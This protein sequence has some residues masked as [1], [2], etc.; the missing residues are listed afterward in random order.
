MFVK[1][2]KKVSLVLV[3]LFVFC[4]Y[5][6]C[7]NNLDGENKT[8]ETTDKI[9]QILPGAENCIASLDRTYYTLVR[10]ENTSEAVLQKITELINEIKAKSGITID[11]KDDFLKKGESADEST[12]FLIGY[13]NR[14]Q[15]K[16][17]MA[18]IG[19]FDW[20]IDIRGNK[21]VLA[22]HTEDA[23]LEAISYLKDQLIDY[24]DGAI[25]LRETYYCK[26]DVSLLFTDDNKLGDY[27]IIYPSGEAEIEIL[28]NDFKELLK[29]RYGVD[30]PVHSDSI[31]A[32]ECEILL[33]AV[34]R[35]EVS[36]YVSGMSSLEEY[37]HYM[38]VSGKKILF[39]GKNENAVETAIENFKLQNNIETPFSYT[40]NLKSDLSVKEIAYV[41]DKKSNP[42][43]DYDLRVMSYNILSDNLGSTG[44]NTSKKRCPR[45]C[46]EFMY[47]MPDIV[48]VQEVDAVAYSLMEEY[49]GHTYA[50]T[51]KTN[52]DKYGNDHSYT[53]IL[54]N[55][56]TLRLI[57]SG[58]VNY[59]KVYN[60]LGGQTVNI[61]VR[62]VNWGVFEKIDG[63][64]QFI[65]ISTHWNNNN[66]G[67]TNVRSYQ[68]AQLTEV[69]NELVEKYSL[70]VFSTG[71]F[72]SRSTQNY[73]VDYLNNTNQSNSHD[74]AAVDMSDI[75]GDKRIDHITY[76]PDA[77]E[78]VYYRYQ[79]KPLLD[80]ASDHYPVCAD[81]KLKK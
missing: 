12:E 17:A 8:T 5:L 18:E 52:E 51:S 68:A 49:I 44:T 2:I 26:S 7:T 27:S 72:N 4:T 69:V 25:Y 58:V 73:F 11:V 79:V 59:D 41:Y 45:W 19:Y 67:T 3:L 53:S 74:N 76:T 70:P 32:S 40:L 47:R 29:N 66:H 75:I 38:G 30:I 60:E 31:A 21:M 64:E 78:V 62:I 77:F 24:E 35:A 43:N 80:K 37:E 63:G 54:Y 71:D 36:K 39:V 20:S 13:T 15:T 33:G 42:S 34:D 16:E 61:N 48:G 28:A 9:S 50:F 81:F 14:N 56:T 22:A 10:P 23:L 55:K 65:F 57:D 46:A 1:F 6:G